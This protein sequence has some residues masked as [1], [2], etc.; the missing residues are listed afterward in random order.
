MGMGDFYH[1]QL[2]IRIIYEKFGPVCK[3]IV[4]EVFK[5]GKLTLRQ[6]INV[7]K[8]NYSVV[9]RALLIL[10]QHNHISY[11]PKSTS[12]KNTDRVNYIAVTRNILMTLWLPFLLSYIRDIF[13]YLGEKIIFN[14]REYG[15]LTA[16]QCI[17]LCTS[18]L[19]KTKIDVAIKK[20]RASLSVRL[21]NEHLIER[22]E[23]NILNVSMNTNTKPFTISK[24]VVSSHDSFENF[25]SKN[26]LYTFQ[27]EKRSSIFWR[28]GYEKSETLLR[29]N[30]CIDLI[31]KRYDEP[32]ESLVRT[33][34]K[35]LPKN[36]VLA[37]KT[38]MAKCTELLREMNFVSKACGQSEKIHEESILSISR[39]VMCDNLEP[40][41]IVYNQY[42]LISFIVNIERIMTFVQLKHLKTLTYQRFGSECSFNVSGH[43]ELTLRTNLKLIYRML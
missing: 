12:G 15:S 26:V 16:N 6:I 3:N 29:L 18:H 24:Q 43:C 31:S 41:T 42:A 4:S 38:K 9:G 37:Q 34:L 27:N 40:V 39:T 23:P 8:F 5:H 32:G 20:I 33:M 1:V 28:F 22:S 21:I 19:R 2:V 25:H 36:Q 7:T 14:V 11:I 13:G 10:V 17:K 30:K 35:L